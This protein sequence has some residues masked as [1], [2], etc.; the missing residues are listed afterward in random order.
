M[1]KAL[2]DLLKA[3]RPQP[4]EKVKPL[5]VQLWEMA[6]MQL[7]RGI[8]PRYYLTAALNR[9]DRRGAEV[10]GHINAEEYRRFIHRVN[11][12]E[13]RVP[14]NSKVEQKRRLTAAGI[15][16]PAL[17]YGC[18]PGT[19]NGAALRDA[20]AQHIGKRV[21]V[22]P[23]SSYGGEGF[24]VLTVVARDGGIGVAEAGSAPI[25]PAELIEA[26]G[27]GL[28][29][30]TYVD[31]HPWYAK[32]N[33]SSVNTWRVWVMKPA[34][35]GPAEVVLAYLRIGRAGS[36]VDNMG[37]GGIYAPLNSDGRLGAGGDGGIFRRRFNAHPDSGVALDQASPPFVDEALA[38]A[39][40]AL[41]AIPALTFAGMDIAVSREGPVVIEINAEPDRMGAARV[42]L[43]FRRWLAERGIES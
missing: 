2:L 19:A 23:T 34:D 14:L 17:I 30:E 7:L 37:G 40:Q 38:L 15:P 21:A 22:K 1:S 36:A 18:E 26:M 24:R 33:A 13:K 11:P 9:S 32:L 29:A 25:S 42:G 5:P 4:H 12:P 43:P 31:Q 8:G 27:G 39:A 35:G 6:R 28:V 16:T 3:T 10:L 20:L 41:D